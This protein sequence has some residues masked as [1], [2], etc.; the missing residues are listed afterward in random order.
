MNYPKHA[1]TQ[2]GEPCVILQIKNTYFGDYFICQDL[3]GDI[4]C[5]DVESITITE[6]LPVKWL[7]AETKKMK[8]GIFRE[9]LNHVTEQGVVTVVSEITNTDQRMVLV[10][11]DK[12][13]FILD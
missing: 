11:F 3:H 9:W 7:D 6:G 4:F 1:I 8:F 12:F 10:E 2:D 13:N 5:A